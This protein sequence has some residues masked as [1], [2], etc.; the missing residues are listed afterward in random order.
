VDWNHAIFPDK[1][2]ISILLAKMGKNIVGKGRKSIFWT[3][4]Y[5]LLSNMGE[6]AL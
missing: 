3:S 1:S 4:M 2:K 6:E 5:N